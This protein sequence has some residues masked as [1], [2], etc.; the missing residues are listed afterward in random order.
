VVK[1]QSKVFFL[2]GNQIYS[3]NFTEKDFPLKL[4]HDSTTFLTK[5]VD[6]G[7]E[8]IV[9]ACNAKNQIIV[10]D[11]YLDDEV[12]IIDSPLYESDEVINQIGY[13]P[14]LKQGFINIILIST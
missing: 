2:S 11:Y 9:F 13:L 8:E 3:I 6:V 1:N 4:L 12:C 14:L 7:E 10:I 5:I